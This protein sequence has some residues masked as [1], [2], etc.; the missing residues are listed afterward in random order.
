M[1]ENELKNYLQTNIKIDSNTQCWNWQ[2]KLKGGYGRVRNNKKQMQVH[3]ASYQVFTGAIPDGLIVRHLCNNK[4]CINPVHLTIG[5]YKDN[6]NDMLKAGIVNEF[7]GK[8]KRYDYYNDEIT[9]KRKRMFLKKMNVSNDLTICWQWLG[10]VKNN[11]GAYHFELGKIHIWT[12]HKA[13]FI[14]HT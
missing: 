13:S 3:R 9:E 6:Y 8:Y 1:T 11:Y 7:S 4:Q 14:I 10:R 2:G 5:T 12:A